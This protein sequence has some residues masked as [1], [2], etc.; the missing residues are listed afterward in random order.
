VYG[1]ITRLVSDQ[2][3]KHEDTV[4][5]QL[6]SVQLDINTPFFA[7]LVGKVT[8]YALKKLLDELARS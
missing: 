2:H 3:K 1:N 6:V 5:Q 7:P 4:A 8:S